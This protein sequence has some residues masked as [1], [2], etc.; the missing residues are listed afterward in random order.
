[1]SRSF[2]GALVRRTA[3]LVGPALAVGTATGVASTRSA[4]FPDLPIRLLGQLGALVE[5]GVGAIC[6]TPWWAVIALVVGA[7]LSWRQAA[8]QGQP[9]GR[10]WDVI[11]SITLAVCAV[12]LFTGL[13]RD[14][15]SNFISHWQCWS[16]PTDL[17][18][19]GDTFTVGPGTAR[20]SQDGL[21]Y[22]LL[23]RLVWAIGSEG[24]TPLRWLSALS[25]LGAAAWTYTLLARHLS[26]TA[27]IVGTVAFATSPLIIDL[28]HVPSFLG[29]S[30]LLVVALVDGMLRWIE[31]RGERGGV[32]LGL[33]MFVGLYAYSPIRFLHALLPLAGLFVLLQR[34]GSLW[35]RLAPLLPMAAAFVLPL[36]LVMGLSRSDPVDLFYA[37]GEFLPTQ[38]MADDDRFRVITHTHGLEAIGRSA[39][40]LGKICLTGEVYSNLD[41]G[42]AGPFT[43]VHVTW[44]LLG[45]CAAALGRAWRRPTGWFLAIAAAA[46]IATMMLMYPPAMRRMIVFAPLLLLVGAGGVELVLPRSVR[47]GPSRA[48]RVG[49]AGLALLLFL[50]SALASLPALRQP[51][52]AEMSDHACGH[53]RWLTDQA[54]ERGRVV[55]LATDPEIETLAASGDWCDFSA[56]IWEHHCEILGPQEPPRM[57]EFRITDATMWADRSPDS[58]ILDAPVV[59]LGRSQKLIFVD[60]DS[61]EGEAALDVLREQRA[62]TWCH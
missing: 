51:T 60:Q 36:A 59:V 10:D 26:G 38:Q 31:S 48:A 40:V 9:G 42:V 28:A 44:I 61:A 46:Q 39:V 13:D 50:P 2:A 15:G 57:G 45:L 30:V 20:C 23:T 24:W 37:D 11:A 47:E 14:V 34:N 7:G 52:E 33:G 49:I 19:L 8:D 41:D 3:L 6:L 25:V 29:P 43:A 22:Q 56:G 21:P 1:M 17:L 5:G 54:I 18:R 55:L 27:A 4:I 58:S 53:A 16:C 62:V 35:N 12:P 32:L